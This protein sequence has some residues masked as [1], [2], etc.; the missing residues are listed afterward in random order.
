MRGAARIAERLQVCGP[1]LVG[2]QDR[3][4]EAFG[5]PGELPAL[6]AEDLLAALPR[7]KKRSGGRVRWVLPRELGS[8]QVG[9]AVPEEVVADVVRCLLP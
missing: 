1:E 5:L 7:D 6:L 4:L 8:A 3:L 2:A 9:L